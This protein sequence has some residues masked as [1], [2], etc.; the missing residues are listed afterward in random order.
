[1]K[2]E[3]KTT[4]IRQWVY[5]FHSKNHFNDDPK[6]FWANF[7][8]CSRTFNS[9]YRFGGDKLNCAYFFS[10]SEESLIAEAFHY[11]TALPDNFKCS[12]RSE[13][14]KTICT[15]ENKV[16][17][18]VKINIDNILDLSDGETFC[19]VISETIGSWAIREYF[20][21]T[22]SLI[23]NE[24]SGGDDITNAI[25]KYALDLG[26]GG[27]L[28]PSTRAFEW[29]Y[30]IANNAYTKKL[31]YRSRNIKDVYNGSLAYCYECEILNNLNILIF[32]GYDVC[33]S[34]EEYEWEEYCKE[35]EE[36][37]RNRKE[38]DYYLNKSKIEQERISNRTHSHLHNMEHGYLT[39]KEI[40]G[41]FHPSTIFIFDRLKQ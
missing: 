4:D 25:G 1:M 40:D 17:F 35:K 16:F 23:M 24:D 3:L 33:S 34:I 13:L 30:P 37:E 31:I 6:D 15:L 7:A 19:T 9:K 27:I 10:L 41:E 14:I 36:P 12:N 11:A 26:Y 22:L 18:K 38:N 39:D 20:L 5:R 32:K 29:Q 2:H 28:F 8:D 21:H